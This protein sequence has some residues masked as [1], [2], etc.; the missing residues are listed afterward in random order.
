MLQ[1]KRATEVPVQHLAAQAAAQAALVASKKPNE[2][3]QALIQCLRAPFAS[4]VDFLA[5][6]TYSADD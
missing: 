1:A 2:A 4:S 5:S 3:I 6:L